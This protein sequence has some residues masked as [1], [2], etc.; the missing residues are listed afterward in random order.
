MNTTT[1]ELRRNRAQMS[2][3]KDKQG[4]KEFLFEILL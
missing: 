2:M 4:P 3:E 1:T